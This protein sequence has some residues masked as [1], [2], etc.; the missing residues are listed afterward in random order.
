MRLVSIANRNCQISPGGQ[1][2]PTS[3][4]PRAHVSQE[5]IR[6]IM[7]AS[8]HAWQRLDLI[9]ASMEES[10]T[11]RVVACLCRT[12][13]NSLRACKSDVELYAGD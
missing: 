6:A 4:F 3:M 7:P 1:A 2:L 11:A 13:K 10:M 8:R 12:K 5:L 9:M